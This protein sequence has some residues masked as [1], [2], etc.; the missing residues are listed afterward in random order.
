M[1]IPSLTKTSAISLEKITG[2]APGLIDTYRSAEATLRNIDL[3]G[4]RAAVYLVLDRSGSMR[5]F[6]ND[7]SVQRLSEQALGLAAHFDDDGIVPLTFFSTGVHTHKVRRGLLHRSEKTIDLSLDNYQGRVGAIHNGLG[8]MGRTYYASGMEAV[9]EHY[10]QSKTT[11]PAFVIFQT[12]GAPDDKP[13][14]TK[15]LKDVAKLPIF[16]QFI[17]FGN[18]PFAYLRSLDDMPVP[19]ARIVDNAGFFAAGD[20]P[21]A[22]TDNH[23]YSQLMGEFP[24]WLKAAREQGILR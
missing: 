2:T 12:D 18:D 8:H 11:A 7:G 16:W 13:A 14:T 10:Q 19:A 4:L 21:S 15:L 1:S 20:N 23:L 9:I 6:Y 3:L 22:L 24:K 5:R 17:G